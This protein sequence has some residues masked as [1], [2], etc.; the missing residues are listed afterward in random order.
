[1]EII[2]Y[3]GRNQI[4]KNHF[5]ELVPTN[6]LFKEFVFNE[7]DEL[8][9]NEFD[10]FL[11]ISDN[12][13]LVI[14]FNEYN[15]KNWKEGWPLGLPFPQNLSID[16]IKVIALIKENSNNFGLNLLDNGFA[17][18][19]QYP[20]YKERFLGTIINTFRNI[21]NEKEIA[22]LYKIGIS[23][24]SQSDLEQLLQEI[25]N[26]SL[27]FTNADGGSIYLVLPETDPVTG[28]KLMQFER[29]TSDT[30]GDRYQK[31]KMKINSNSLA[32]YAILTGKNQNIQDVYNLPKNMPYSFD[33]SFDKKNNY[34]CKSMLVVPMVNH[35]NEIIGAIQLI[36][37]KKN[38]NIK[39]TSNEIVE[40]QV[41]EFNHKNELLIRSL[42]SQ[43]T[44]AVETAQLY[45]E[46]HDLFES[47]MEASVSA[48][49][50]RD[51]STAG[52]SRRVSK[53]SVAIANHINM[54]SEGP[55]S[56]YNFS[57]TDLQSIK[58]A[59]LLHDFGKIGVT[60]RIL[61]KAKKLF[62]E[63]LVNIDT[64]MELL[65]YSYYN[66]KHLQQI[67]TILSEVDDL[68][69]AIFQAN[70]PGF[71]S[72]DI[73]TKLKTAKEISIVC[74][75][76]RIKP[77]LEDDEYDRLIFSRGSLSNNEYEIMKSHVEHTYKFLSFIKWPKGLE[78]VPEIARYHHEKLDGTGYPLG[79]KGDKIPIESQIMCIADIFDALISSDRPY[80]TRMPVTKA[81]DILGREADEG[82][83]NKDI[84]DFMLEN[85]IY[86]VIMESK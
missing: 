54:V 28:E 18:F 33:S 42:G 45:K 59:G 47:F 25:L 68:K 6:Y 60:E 75:D 44:I 26:A 65:K 78:K 80:K 35:K 56:K 61:L 74:L 22:S 38:R 19:I 41:V 40:K 20:F 37:K 64:R 15:E 69:N 72:N 17:D 8:N 77:V 50:S 71:L 5:K 14:D 81:L 12:S 73:N 21:D 10:D 46:I 53:L 55:L 62:S 27:D 79:I 29:S 66:K 9:D 67:K 7:K 85:S 1:M 11:N 2:Y 48:V 86:E 58:Y 63:E 39:L 52:H 49:E 82:K 16:N 23:L 24:S 57:V 43:A 3:Y 84:F 51:P 36:N 4:I 70:E 34:R 83:I 76:D 32:G 30:L 31:I 13:I